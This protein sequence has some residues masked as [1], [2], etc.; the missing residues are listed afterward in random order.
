MNE[1][2]SE[3]DEAWVGLGLSTGVE[4]MPLEGHG[5]KVS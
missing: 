3:K 4:K 1:K 2:Q 5:E